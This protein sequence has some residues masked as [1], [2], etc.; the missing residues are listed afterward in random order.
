MCS[1]ALSKKCPE[2]GIGVGVADGKSGDPI[3]RALVEVAIRTVIINVI[4]FIFFI[5]T[6]DGLQKEGQT[7]FL[8]EF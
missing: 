6:P 7:K 4:H 8:M 1:D 3:F 5:L 2:E